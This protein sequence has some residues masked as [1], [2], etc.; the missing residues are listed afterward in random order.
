[1]GKKLDELFSEVPDPRVINRCEHKLQDILFIALCTLICNGEDF[2]DMVLFGQQHY[3]WLSEVLELPSGIP[4][5]DTF[6]RVLQLLEPDALSDVL[7]EDGRVLL[8]TLEDKQI[9]FDGKKARGVSPQ[10]R[11]NKGLYILSAWVSETGICIGQQKVGDKSNE[12]TAIPELIDNLVLKGTVSSVDAIGCQKS[13]AE[14]IID[15]EGD[16]LLALK[17]NQKESYM[18]VEDAFRFH[19]PDRYDQMSEKVSAPLKS[20]TTFR[21][22]VLPAFFKK[23]RKM[24][25][26]CNSDSG[27]EPEPKLGRRIPPSLCS[28]DVWDYIPKTYS[29]KKKSNRSLCES[30]KIS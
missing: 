30:L 13:I 6:N 22:K 27:I 1:M 3:S 8:D 15:K 4:S 12:I 21:R 7:I 19:S 24:I 9:C 16:Y 17:Q 20:A 28:I 14:K 10:S 5:H 29:V 25:E 11:G 18:M 26:L 2:E 23:S